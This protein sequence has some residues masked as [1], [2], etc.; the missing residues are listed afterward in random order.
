MTPEEHQLEH[1]RLHRALDELIAC[2]ISEN[3]GVAIGEQRA[4]IHDEIYTLMKWSHR[5]TLT[6]SPAPQ[7]PERRA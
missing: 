5:K 3:V 4:S 2:Y 6:P 1:V 7:E